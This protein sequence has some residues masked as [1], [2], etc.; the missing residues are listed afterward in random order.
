MFAVLMNVV[1]FSDSQSPQFQS[2]AWETFKSHKSLSK[3]VNI[4]LQN[5]ITVV[6]GHK[7]SFVFDVP[8]SFPHKADFA[9][10]K[11]NKVMG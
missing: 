5:S 8:Q 6:W 11:V 2:E 7:T 4:L 1:L 9:S 10:R 3:H